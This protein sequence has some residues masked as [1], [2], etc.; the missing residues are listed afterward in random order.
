[1]GSSLNNSNQQ[2]SNQAIQP[3]WDVRTTPPEQRRLGWGTLIRSDILIVPDRTTLNYPTLNY[4][5]LNYPTQA[6]PAWMGHPDRIGH[7][8]CS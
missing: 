6:K 2:M 1:L 8:D 4:P 3:G 5:T 7:P